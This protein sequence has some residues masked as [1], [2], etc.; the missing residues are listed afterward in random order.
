MNQSVIARRVEECESDYRVTALIPAH[1]RDRSL[2]V[3]GEDPEVLATW[4]DQ[5]LVKLA[6]H[7]KRL[8]K[9]RHS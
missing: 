5:H 6:V 1:L 7:I 9:L 3:S 4:Y 2:Q 8:K